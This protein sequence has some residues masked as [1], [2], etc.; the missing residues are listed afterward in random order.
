MPLVKARGNMYEFVTHCHSHLRGGCPHSCSYCYVRSFRNYQRD[1]TGPVRLLEK[2]LSVNYGEGKTIFIE[3]CS[4]MFAE[5]VPDEYVSK[6]IDHCN[7]YEG[8]TYLFQTKN[9]KRMLDWY[10][11]LPGDF[12]VILGTTIETNRRLDHIMSASTGE[13]LS[14]APDPKERYEAMLVASGIRK[15]SGERLMVT[16]EPIMEFDL[17]V[18]SEWIINLKPDFINLGADS[19]RHNL[20]EPTREEVLALVNVLEENGVHINKKSNLGR[21]VK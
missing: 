3:H 5:G 4:D 14:K 21:L 9:P 13:P 10:E 8:N 16:I 19:K 18:L 7:K 15:S 2:E 12:N 11:F 17:D 1:W 20:P 6:I